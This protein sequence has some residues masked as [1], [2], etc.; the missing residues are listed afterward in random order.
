MKKLTTFIRSLHKIEVFDIL[1]QLYI[2]TVLL[3]F[4]YDRLKQNIKL[5]KQPNGCYI[6]D[7]SNLVKISFDISINTRTEYIIINILLKENQGS[8]F[9]QID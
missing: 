2:K 5:Q 7:G 9:N 8:D 6:G 3:F 1:K 4:Q